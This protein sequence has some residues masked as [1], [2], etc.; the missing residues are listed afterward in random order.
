M[1]TQRSIA[2]CKGEDDDDENVGPLLRA[3][4][5]SHYA[6]LGDDAIRDV[7]NYRVIFADGTTRWIGMEEWSLQGVFTLEAHSFCHPKR[8]DARR[9]R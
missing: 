5:E 8:R 3:Q 9:H 7:W 4:C 1:R 2:Q 6:E